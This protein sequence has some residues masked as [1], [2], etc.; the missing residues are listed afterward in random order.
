MG[1]RV[2]DIHP[3]YL[4]RQSLLGQHV[5]IHA[6]FS[7]ITGGKEGY[8]QHPET[9]RWR[10]NLCRLIK[11]HERTVAEMT[12]RGFGHRSPLPQVACTSGDSLSWVDPPHL[13]FGL[14]HQKYAGTDR[15]GRIPLP[16]RGSRFWAQ[17]KYAVMGRGYNCYKDIQAFMREK[18]DCPI[19][20]EPELVLR[21]LQITQLPIEPRA[22]IN[23]LDHLWGYFKKIAGVPEKEVYLAKIK[24]DPLSLLPFFY[25]LAC[26]YEIE[27]L[28]HSTIFTDGVS[29]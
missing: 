16:E 3:G 19:M 4:S 2:W 26:K 14:L 8:A 1:M 18:Q 7:I 29:L 12:L 24:E 27:Y 23:T 13:Q 28:V 5:E 15:M 17:H 6:I 11:V 21:V 22:L 10:N 25:Q 9:M 20:Q